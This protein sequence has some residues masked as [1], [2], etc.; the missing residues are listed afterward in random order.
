VDGAYGPLL[1]AKLPIRD[2]GLTHADQTYDVTHVWNGGFFRLDDHMDRFEA[3]L[4]GMR[5]NPRLTRAEM[6][7]VLEGC[8]RRSGLRYA[9]VYWACTRGAPP[10]GSR[11]PRA[12]RSVF[13]A[14]AQPLV[15][16]G[17]PA[18][19]RRGLAVR[20]SPDVRRIPPDSLNPHWKNVHWGDFTRALFDAQDLGFDTTLLL[21]HQGRV[22]EGPGF[23]VMALVRGELVC[24]AE[25]TL[26]GISARTMLEIAAELGLPARYGDLSPEDLRQSEEAFITSTSTGLFPITRVDDRVLS[27]GAPG[28]VAVRLLN[29]YYRR[30]QAGWRITPIRYEDEGDV[31]G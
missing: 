3:S 14:Y 15:L 16:R 22:T 29:E 20:I 13:L 23:N 11:D 10:P 8:V 9:L 2:F 6:V 26:E 5:L 1:D 17:G 18:E 7:A 12:A 24:P 28:P 30:K 27:N 25:G 21:D 4:A 31:T 19:M